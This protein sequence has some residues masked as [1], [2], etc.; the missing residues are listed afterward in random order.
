LAKK[1]TVVNHEKCTGC[2]ICIT[3]CA[4]A[5]YYPPFTAAL[6]IEKSPFNEGISKIE[7]C[8]SCEDAPCV[9]ACPS[10]YLI[11]R[12]N[13]GVKV[14]KN[15]ECIRCGNCISHCRYDFLQASNDGIPLICRHCGICA[16]HCPNDVFIMVENNE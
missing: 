15:A 14:D 9:E 13:G 7:I 11:K 8:L 5:N 12:E 3:S 16:M 6:R 10:G 1:L 2:G 4:T